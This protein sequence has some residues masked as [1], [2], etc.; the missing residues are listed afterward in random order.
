MDKTRRCYIKAKV[1]STLYAFSNLEFPVNIKAIC[2]S[3]KNIRLVPYSEQMRRFNLTYNEMINLA[4]SHDGTTVYKK[5][6]DRYIIFYNDIDKAL[7]TSNRYRWS[8]AHELGHIILEHH[9]RSDKTK[10]FRNSLTGTE[11]KEIEDEADYFAAHILVPH[12]VLYNL[13]ITTYTDIMD[14]CKISDLAARNRF[15]HYRKWYRQNELGT[16]DY[17]TQDIFS[18]ARYTKFCYDCGYAQISVKDTYCPICDSK[19]L[20]WGVGRMKY[21]SNIEL[22]NNSKAKICPICK[23]EELE[24]GDYCNICGSYLINHCDNRP[25]E[26]GFVNESACGNLLSSNSRYCPHC[27]NRSTF[28]NDGILKAWNAD[29]LFS[30]NDMEESID[31]DEALPFN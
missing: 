12:T 7:I 29:L 9:K 21:I 17:S 24:D 18:K 5:S 16:Y 31:I 27:G 26:N 3:K 1:L 20:R 23:N 11:Y 6:K 28:F 10:L 15:N 19:D 25:F 30:D 4:E 13:K 8:I 14:C 22:D 2:E